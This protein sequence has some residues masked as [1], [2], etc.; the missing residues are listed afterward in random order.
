MNMLVI[1]YEFSSSVKMLPNMISG[2]LTRVINF[3]DLNVLLK[4]C[5]E[6][7]LLEFT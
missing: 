3:M 6:E 7:C 2:Q 4:L 5:M 1:S